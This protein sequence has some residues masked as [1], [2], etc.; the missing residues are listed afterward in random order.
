VMQNIVGASLLA[1][2]VCQAI[3]ISGMGIDRN[4]HRLQQRSLQGL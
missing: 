4:S 3:H 1:K 2:A